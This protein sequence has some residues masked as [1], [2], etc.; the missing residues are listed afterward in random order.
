VNQARSEIAMSKWVGWSL[1]ELHRAPAS[2][3]NQIAEMMTEEADRM[4]HPED[5]ADE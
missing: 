3:V 1:D 2:Y 4:K 5:Y